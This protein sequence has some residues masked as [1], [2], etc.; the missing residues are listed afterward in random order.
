MQEFL[1]QAIATAVD[2]YNTGRSNEAVAILCEVL[3]IDS[4]NELAGK[5]M[6]VIAASQFG[7]SPPD[8]SQEFGIPWNGEDLNHKS[9]QIFCDQGMGDNLNLLR[10]VAELKRR[11][12]VSI[13][14]NCYA[15]YE[16]LK[17]LFSRLDFFEFTNSHILCDYFVNI[18]SLPTIL[19]KSPVVNYPVHFHEAMKN[20]IPPQVNFGQ[21]ERKFSGFNVGVAWKS[22]VLNKLSEVKSIEVSEFKVLLDIGNLHCLLPSECPDFMISHSINDMEDTANLI[23]SMDVIVS[24]DTAVLHLAGCLNKKTYALLPMDYDPRWSGEICAWYPS[25]EMYKKKNEWSDLLEEIAI[26][27]NRLKE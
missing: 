20:E 23:N 21:F 26:E 19:N 12:E 22:N 6:N 13:V 24:I 5:V 17:R 4:N 1:I 25:V 14:V 10:Y 18:M 3:K 2:K 8:I 11:Y 16:Q 7:F 15:F 9:I 27:I